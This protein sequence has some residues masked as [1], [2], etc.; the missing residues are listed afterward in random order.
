MH[1]F[2]RVQVHAGLLD[3]DHAVFR[4]NVSLRRID[5]LAR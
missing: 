4:N 2:L 5:E 1:R 3:A